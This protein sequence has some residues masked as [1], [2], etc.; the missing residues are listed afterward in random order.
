M[1]AYD[2]DFFRD[3]LGDSA[4]LL[5]MTYFLQLILHIILS[6]FNGMESITYKIGFEEMKHRVI[7]VKL[8]S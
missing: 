1:R 5:K 6:F 8:V 2:H 4:H 3:R 7:L